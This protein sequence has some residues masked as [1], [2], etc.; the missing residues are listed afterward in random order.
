MGEDEDKK[1]ESIDWSKLGDT[2]SNYFKSEGKEGEEDT[3]KEKAAKDFIKETIEKDEKEKKA[4]EKKSDKRT[5]KIRTRK[6]MTSR[7][8]P[9]SQRSRQL[10][11]T[12]NL[13]TPGWIFLCSTVTPLRRQGQSWQHWTRQTKSEWRRKLL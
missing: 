2:I 3:E 12:S 1:D 10:K 5:Q 11:P 6:K 8:S 9:R 7:R 4:K 13:R